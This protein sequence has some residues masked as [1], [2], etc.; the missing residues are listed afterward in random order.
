MHREDAKEE[1]QGAPSFGFGSERWLKVQEFFHS[2]IENSDN[3][4]CKD[5]LNRQFHSEYFFVSLSISLNNWIWRFSDH[6]T[7][8]SSTLYWFD[9]T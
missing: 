1:I 6:S 3:N 4:Y 2:S 5:W 8:E 7:I 9:T